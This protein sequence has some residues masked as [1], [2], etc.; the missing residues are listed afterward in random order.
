METLIKYTKT[1]LSVILGVFL[2]SCTYFYVA[3][4]MST[5]PS[6]YE[7]QDFDNVSNDLPSGEQKAIKKSRNSNVRVFSKDSEDGVAASTGTYIEANGNYYVVTVSHGV[8]GPCEELAIWTE[9]EEFMACE[10]YIVIDTISDYAIIKVG[11]IPSRTPV[12]IPESLPDSSEWKQALSIQK[13]TYYTGFPNNSGP[14]TIDGRIIGVT[15]GGYIYIKSYAWRGASGSGIFNSD[16][17]Y[18]GLVFAV[19]MGETELGI[20]VFENVIIAVP[21]F[22]IDW[23][24]IIK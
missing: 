1:F 9:E 19:D 5:L 6:I 13:Q 22:A 7:I 8:L 11:E 3:H 17:K 12:K 2:S 20:D 24:T 23:S 14:L 4:R 18:I 10:E 15:N 16:G 21:T